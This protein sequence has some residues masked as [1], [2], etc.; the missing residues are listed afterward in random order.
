MIKSEGSIIK[1]GFRDENGFVGLCCILDKQ[2]KIL[3]ES[4]FY[5]KGALHGY[6]L[7]N[8]EN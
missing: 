7:L 3:K 1:I 6:G 5:K 8:S 4:G 2:L